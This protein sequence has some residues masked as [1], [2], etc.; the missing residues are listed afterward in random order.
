MCSYTVHYEIYPAITGISSIEYEDNRVTVFDL[1]K[2]DI[3]PSIGFNNDTLGVVDFVFMIYEY[4]RA[5][6]N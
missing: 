2:I 5:K 4:K 6:L 3:H 1:K